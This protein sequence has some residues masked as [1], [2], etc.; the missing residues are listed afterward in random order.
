MWRP[1]VKQSQRAKGLFTLLL[2]TPVLLLQQACTNLDEDPSS[3]ITPDNF[4][5]N[6]EEVLGGLAG[7]YAQLRSTEWAYFNLAEI[8]SDEAVVPTRG[9]D[10]F[11]NGRWLEIHRQV[12]EANSPAG[13]EDINAAWND[14]FTGIARANA[15]ITALEELSVPVP[16]QDVIAAEART[17]RAFYYY[18]L[19]DLFGGVPIVTTTDIAATPRS[20]RREV[21]DFIE[22]ELLAARPVLPDQ[23]GANDHGRMT[24]GAADA[25]LANMYLNAGVF[26]TETPNATAYNSCSGVQVAGGQDACDAAIEAADRILNSG[27][28]SLATDWRSNFTADNFNSPENILVV[29]HLNESGLGLNFVMRTL[30]YNQFNPSP[31]NGF[32]I[33]A[34]AYNS[35]DLDDDERTEIFLVGPQVNL[36][37][38]EPVT[39]RSGDPLVFTPEIG[40]ITSATE[41][42]G[43]RVIKYPPDP[44]HVAQENGNDFVY[45]RLGEIYL[46]KAEALNEKN[47]GSGTALDLLN[48]LRERVFDPDE[49]L[50]AISRD[51]ILQERLFELTWEAKR[52]QD[53]IRHGK[54]TAPW[55]FKAQREDHR[56]LMPIPQTQ[57]DVNPELTQNPGY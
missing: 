9:Q 10:W 27:V 47:P 33:L 3:A 38:G 52:R 8:S 14:A 37:T 50:P 7:V 45:F 23:W 55:E 11:D 35:F 57:L 15:L 48:D 4:Y 1:P 26:T 53:L 30:H 43:V 46:I 42:E 12:W 21:F 2:L 16:N 6:E 34:D 41:G 28:Y 51:V 32:A 29:T 49:D 56:V 5:Q 22:Q 24:Q 54:Y 40:D 20:S 36:E 31:W 19:M 39:N 13:L 17:L 18:Q 25:I 44:N